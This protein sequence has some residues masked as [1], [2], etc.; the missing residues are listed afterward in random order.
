VFLVAINNRVVGA[1]QILVVVALS[2]VGTDSVAAVIALNGNRLNFGVK[3]SDL[4]NVFGVPV[5]L[6]T[7]PING[8][9]R[10]SLKTTRPERQ[11]DTRRGLREAPVLRCRVPGILALLGSSQLAIDPPLNLVGCPPQF[12]IM[13]VV[14]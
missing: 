14:E 12:I 8:T 1:T 7:S 3:E 11:L 4:L 13:E 9:L 2:L 5:D 10:V 6:T